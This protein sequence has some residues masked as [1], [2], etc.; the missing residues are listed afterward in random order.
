MSYCGRLG[1]V[2]D[3]LSLQLELMRWMFLL[4]AE[5]ETFAYVYYITHKLD[6]DALVDPY[7]EQVHIA[8]E[9]VCPQ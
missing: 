4:N 3:T 7:R 9:D 1:R 8:L 2:V 6:C 5:I